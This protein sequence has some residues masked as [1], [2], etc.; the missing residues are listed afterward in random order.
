[1][2][3]STGMVCGSCAQAA[4]SFLPNPTY[5]MGEKKK[6]DREDKFG[7]QKTVERCKAVWCSA[8]VEVSVLVHH[9]STTGVLCVVRLAV[10]LQ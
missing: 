2:R 5:F 3:T 4:A 1:M 8:V 6:L 7:E 10:G 9:Y